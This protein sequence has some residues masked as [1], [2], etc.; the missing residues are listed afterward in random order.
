MLEDMD[1]RQRADLWPVIPLPGRQHAVTRSPYL[2][3]SSLVM[4]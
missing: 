3:V 4:R 1:L 2:A